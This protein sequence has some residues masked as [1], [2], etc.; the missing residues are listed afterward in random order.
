MITISNVLGHTFVSSQLEKS[1]IALDCG[2]NLGDFSS[3]LLTNT[4]LCVHCFEPDPRLFP[5]LPTSE[6]IFPIKAAVA[7]DNGQA[8][9]TLGEN[10]CSSMRFSEDNNRDSVMVETVNIED[11]CRANDVGAVALLKL[12]IEGAELDVLESLSDDFL[13]TIE[14]ITVEFHDFLNA[15]DIRR[16]RAICTRLEGLG[17]YLKR[18]SFYTWGDCLFINENLIKLKATEKFSLTLHKYF[19][20]GVRKIRKLLPT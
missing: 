14:Q 11:Y 16:I 2:G 8:N 12:D 17:F 19:S 9:L 4:T 1:S 5:D 13:K 10:Q 7:K 15:S 18:F 6:R 20:A 3:W